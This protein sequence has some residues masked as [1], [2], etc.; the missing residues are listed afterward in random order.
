MYDDRDGTLRR[1]RTRRRTR[2]ASIGS[3]AVAM[4]ALTAAPT[5]AAAPPVGVTGPL[6]VVDADVA[7]FP[8]VSIDIALPRR[9]LR[10]DVNASSFA[11]P[12][13]TALTVEALDPRDLSIEIVLDDAPGVDLAAVEIEQGSMAEL[14]LGLPDGVSVGYHTTSG[15]VVGPTTDRAALFAPLAE[16]G[17]ASSAA[18]VDLSTAVGAAA[19]RLGQS[20]TS[21]RQLVVITHAGVDVTAAAGVRLQE[22]LDTAGAALRAVVIGDVVGPE[23]ARVAALS[24]GASAAVGSSGD[25]TVRAVDILTTTFSDQFRLLVTMAAPGSQTLTLTVG[26]R[27]YETTLPD[28]GV[29]P[30][31]PPPPTTVPS[32]TTTTTTSTTTVPPATTAAPT[33]PVPAADAPGRVAPT[34][35]TAGAGGSGVV[36]VIQAVLIAVTLVGIIGLVVWQWRRRVTNARPAIRRR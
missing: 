30:T 5:A 9:E 1:A 28:L 16:L 26:A 35:V 23:V 2:T 20:A 21:R 3:G 11:A 29:V 18:P 7:A 22:A 25:A 19:D 15:T 13:A 12:G 36:P 17:G 33:T 10:S 8:D 4:W 27:R 24:G 31:T 14:L 32:T 34:P 6:E